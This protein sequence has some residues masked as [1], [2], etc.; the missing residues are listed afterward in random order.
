MPLEVKNVNLTLVNDPLSALEVI[1]RGASDLLGPV[2]L[3]LSFVRATYALSVS[4]ETQGASFGPSQV[5]R[6]AAYCPELAGQLAHLEGTVR[7]QGN[8]QYQPDSSQPWSH[9]VRCQLSHGKLSHPLLPL[10]LEEVEARL[11]SDDG[12]L[13]VENLTAHSGPTHLE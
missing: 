2:Q 5:Q 3:H 9:R 12:R 4:V 10:P 13:S 11:G 8:I 7:V 6:L 1:V